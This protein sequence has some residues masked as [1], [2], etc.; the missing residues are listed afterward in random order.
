MRNI[1]DFGWH[2]PDFG[3][4]IP[5]QYVDE[6]RKYRAVLDEAGFPMTFWEASEGYVDFLYEEERGGLIGRAYLVA[7]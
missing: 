1:T 6:L 5:E 2:H 7:L 3:L 4:V